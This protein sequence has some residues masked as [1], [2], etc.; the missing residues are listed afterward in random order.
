MRTQLVIKP[1][2][3]VYTVY[4][5]TLKVYIHYINTHMYMYM[6]LQVESLNGLS[7]SLSISQSFASFISYVY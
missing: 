4:A 2:D 1:Y 5:K 7:L 3:I 6:C